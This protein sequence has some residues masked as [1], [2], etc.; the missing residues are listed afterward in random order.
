[1]GGGPSVS[2]GDAEGTS[3]GPRWFVGPAVGVA[4]AGADGAE[5]GLM[6]GGSV[7]RPDCRWHG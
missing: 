4:D 5:L 3:E 2:I 6:V 1:M 7:S